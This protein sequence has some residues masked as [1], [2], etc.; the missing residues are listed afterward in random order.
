MQFLGEVSAENVC[1]YGSWE[2]IYLTYLGIK[3]NLDTYVKYQGTSD[4]LGTKTTRLP[5][6]TIFGG[7]RTRPKNVLYYLVFVNIVNKQPTDRNQQCLSE[8]NS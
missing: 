2:P 3:P 1:V 6:R 4:G 5:T 8:Q 7:I